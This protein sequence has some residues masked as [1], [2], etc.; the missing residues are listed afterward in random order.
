VKE[1]EW[2]SLYSMGE[3]QIWGMREWFLFELPGADFPAAWIVTR[4]LPAIPLS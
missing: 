3:D 4:M 2:C 1:Q